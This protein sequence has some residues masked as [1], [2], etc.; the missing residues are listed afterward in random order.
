MVVVFVAVILVMSVNLIPL[1]EHNLF[2]FLILT[3]YIYIYI[4]PPPSLPLEKIKH[5]SK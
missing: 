2:N 5:M 1:V 3:Y 4:Y